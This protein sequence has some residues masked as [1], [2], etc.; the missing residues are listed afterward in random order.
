[1][2]TFNEVEVT[3][4]VSVDFEVFCGTC[5]EGLCGESYTRKSRVRG[6]AQ[7]EVNV[8]PR[9]IKE[10]EEEIERL[11]YEINSLNEEIETLRESIV[12]SVEKIS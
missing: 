3:V 12:S 5:G 1:M 10:K 9:C 2:P 4:E 11:N 7:V 8:C 6:C